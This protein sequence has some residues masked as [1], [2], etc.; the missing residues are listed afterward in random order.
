M[1]I[2]FCA[3][4]HTSIYKFNLTGSAVVGTIPTNLQAIATNGP[5]FA[6]IRNDGFGT[7][8]STVY[9][10]NGAAYATYGST[11]SAPDVVRNWMSADGNRYTTD[12][13]N[14]NHWNYLDNGTGFSLKFRATGNAYR[15]FCNYDG[16]QIGQYLNV[17]NKI[18]LRIFLTVNSDVFYCNITTGVN[19]NA[20]Y[21]AEFNRRGSS[22]YIILVAY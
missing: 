14:S 8:I 13:L 7:Y 12:T 18:V 9:K 21:R 10:F 5:T 20:A 6:L 22:D 17:S 2:F 11:V 1:V 3:N 4:G 19:Y 15:D 16:N